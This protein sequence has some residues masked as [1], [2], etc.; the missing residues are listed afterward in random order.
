MRKMRKMFAFWG[1]VGVLLSS[2]MPAKKLLIVDDS[3]FARR[4]L[5][6]I[7]EDAG[8]EVD[9]AGGGNEALEKYQLGKPDAVLLDIVMGEIDGLEVLQ[10]LR[11][12]DPCA[13]VIM[14][15]ADIQDATRRDAIAAGAVDFVNKPFKA[16]EVVAAARRAFSD[17][18]G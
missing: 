1:D 15:T 3:G 5:R 8:F 16:E 12:V 9:E 6:R 11:E 13:A 7:L 17:H 10:K 2:E 18:P 14:A 4:M